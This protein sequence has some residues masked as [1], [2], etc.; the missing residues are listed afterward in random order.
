[1]LDMQ[2]EY[3]SDILF[4][5]STEWD[6]GPYAEQ[7]ALIGGDIVLEQEIAEQEKQK[8]ERRALIREKKTNIQKLAVEDD[9]KMLQQKRRAALDQWAR[10]NGVLG[11]LPTKQGLK[12]IWSALKSG[13]SLVKSLDGVCTVSTWNKLKREYPVL[14]DMEEACL[15]YR[16]ELLMDEVTK[17]ADQPTRTRMGETAR[18]RLMIDARMKE[19]DRIDK[20]K[21]IKLETEQQSKNKTGTMVPIQI[22]VSY[23]TEEQSGNTITGNI[24]TDLAEEAS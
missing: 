22:N 18:D 20:I 3:D 7:K 12:M 6:E 17:I 24:Q 1:M 19:I 2:Q 5:S 15:E 16:R 8:E 10:D 11:G 13:K 21:D 14:A 23:G 9:Y 4:D